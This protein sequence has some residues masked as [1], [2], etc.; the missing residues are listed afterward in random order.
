M[1]HLYYCA[2]DIDA[3]GAHYQLPITIVG[4][5]LLQP[6]SNQ[7][8][9]QPPLTVG[10]AEQLGITASFCRD[11]PRAS[12]ARRDPAGG[13]RSSV[14]RVALCRAVAAMCSASAAPCGIQG[15]GWTGDAGLASACCAASSST[16][17]R[18]QKQ[19]LC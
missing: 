19:L 13:H 14:A 17:R 9:T 18:R 16:H 10:I 5:T 8:S 6:P 3:Y 7:L 12:I 2:A 15:H 1:L 11:A 4:P